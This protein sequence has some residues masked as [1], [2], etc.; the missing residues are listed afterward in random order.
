MLKLN[1]RPMQMR[2]FC[3]ITSRLE[4]GDLI[5]TR[6][7]GRGRLLMS[8]AEAAQLGR[9]ARIA[10]RIECEAVKDPRTGAYRAVRACALDADA[11]RLAV[12][13]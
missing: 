9:A 5:L 11:R 12:V 13:S 4:N 6:L 7:D 3:A 8:A 10:V 2:V 1:H